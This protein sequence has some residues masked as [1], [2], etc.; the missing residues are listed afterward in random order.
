MS[1]VT[2]IKKNYKL[3]GTESDPVIIAQ[4][5]L[6]LY[7]QL[8]IFS[9]EKKEAYNQ[10][11]LEQ[12]PEVKR[13]LGNLP[14][15]VVL[16]QY[17]ADIEEEYGLEVEDFSIY[18]GADKENVQEEIPLKTH[19][20]TPVAPAVTIASDPNMVQGIVE[21]FKE[22]MIT[23]EK[24]RKEDT[25]E[26][27]QTIVALQSKLTQTILDKNSG[28][29]VNTAAPQ[30]AN[31]DEIISSISKAQGELIKEVAQVQTLVMQLLQLQQKKKIK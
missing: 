23:S 6:N 27:A 17:L 12:T 4:R 13:M 29:V 31:L 8:H 1:E 21:A 20:S 22:A 14:G 7:R 15:G 9:Q 24:N 26:L 28:N 2:K 30:P 10:M 25:K 18:H 16:Q 11:L 5:L 3:L 19:K